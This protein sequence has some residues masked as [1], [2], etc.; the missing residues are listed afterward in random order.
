MAFVESKPV[1]ATAVIAATAV[2]RFILIALI[3][4]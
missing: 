4:A 1:R 3:L 2:T